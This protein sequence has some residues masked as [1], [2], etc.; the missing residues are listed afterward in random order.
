M[1]IIA[2]VIAD[3]LRTGFPE[4]RDE[5][6][7][8][9]C[10]KTVQLFDFV[11]PCLMAKAGKTVSGGQR[12]RIG[13]ARAPYDD[14]SRILI[15]A[16]AASTLDDETAFMDAISALYGKLILFIAA[17]RFITAEGCDWIVDLFRTGEKNIKNKI[18][19]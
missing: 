10:L 15:P 5:Q 19:R 4:K 3:K 14:S 8:I 6:C 1:D 17:H 18:F 16:E 12:Q 11:F 7:V 13:I 2:E 9:Q